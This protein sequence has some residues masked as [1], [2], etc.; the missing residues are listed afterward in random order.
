MTLDFLARFVCS[1]VCWSVSLS[2]GLLKKLWTYFRE[3]FKEVGQ[4]N[5]REE[6]CNYILSALGPN[7]DP[8]IYIAK[9]GLP[10]MLTCIREMAPLT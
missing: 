3:I 8:R 5:T 6:I 1:Y 4:D 2:A 9:Y 10:A 7:W